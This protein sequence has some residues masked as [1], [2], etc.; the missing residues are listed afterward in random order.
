MGQLETL[1]MTAGPP[2]RGMGGRDDF[3]AEVK[4]TLA[5]RVGVRCSNRNCHQLTS[6][7]RSDPG[8]SVNVGVA[9]HITAASPGG[10]RYDAKLTPEERASIDNGIWLCQN[11]G[12]LVDNDEAR[13]TVGLLRELMS[14]GV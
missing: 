6:G 9:A 10:A 1:E 5:E 12:K 7:P 11:C 8:K 3:I 13:Y 2:R 14:R 4:D